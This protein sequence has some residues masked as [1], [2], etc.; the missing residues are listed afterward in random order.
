MSPVF[1]PTSDGADQTYRLLTAI[2]VPRPIA[3]ISSMSSEGELNLAPFSFYNVACPWPPIL[4]TS[5]GRRNRDHNR[6]DTWRNIQETG[7]YVVNLVTDGI[8]EQMNTTSGEYAADVDEFQ[9]AGLTPISSLR[10]KA[11]GVA[12]A[13]VRAECVLDRMIEFDGGS[14]VL[15]LGQIVSIAVAD[16]VWANGRVDLRALK[17][18]GRLSGNLYCRTHDMFTMVRPD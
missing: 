16:E 18:V 5:I 7:E 13:R 11:P 1:D 6:K 14:H 15:V 3:F 8:A 4:S 17:P 10:V 2:V 12:E 9:L